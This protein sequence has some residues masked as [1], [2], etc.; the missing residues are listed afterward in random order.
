MPSNDKF[1]QKM[2]DIIQGLSWKNTK[3][4]VLGKSELEKEGFGML[5]AVSAGS[6]KDPKVVIFERISNQKSPKYA[7]V[8]KGVTF[9]S[10]G[11][12]IK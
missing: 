6:D 5:L 4:R 3:I 7:F 2:V 12:Q 8:G 11:I 10:G 1:P 9:D